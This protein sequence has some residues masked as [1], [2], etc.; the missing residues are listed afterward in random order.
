MRTLEAGSSRYN[1]TRK[2]TKDRR[3]FQVVCVRATS[4]CT[5][6][7]FGAACRLLGEKLAGAAVVTKYDGEISFLSTARQS[8]PDNMQETAPPGL[9]QRI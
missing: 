7:I 4:V 9:C 8:V 1:G 5:F 6:C 2:K 3:S